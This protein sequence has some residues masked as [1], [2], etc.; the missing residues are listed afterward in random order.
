MRPPSPPPLSPRFV[1]HIRRIRW[2]MKTD[3]NRY[4]ADIAV[5]KSDMLRVQP[6]PQTGALLRRYLDEHGID[7]PDGL[8]TALNMAELQACP[9]G[10]FG[11]AVADFMT[12]NRLSPF[13]LRATEADVVARNAFTLRYAITHDVFHTLLGFDTSY[14][15][16]YGVL[17]FARAQNYSRSQ[18]LASWVAGLSYPVLSGG[19][20]R[21]LRAA[22]R[23][24]YEQGVRSVHLLTQPLTPHF[25]RPLQEVRDAFRLSA[26]APDET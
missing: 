24:G 9:P 1:G 18:V 20:L 22:W 16:E 4:L 26:W 12:R 15:G 7:G 8:A 21:E 2:Y 10:C 3:L 11:R 5:T 14:V 17:A 6:S 19:R 25:E 23:H 13:E